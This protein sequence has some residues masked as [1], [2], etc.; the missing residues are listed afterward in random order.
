[1]IIADIVTLT[2]KNESVANSG[3][4]DIDDIGEGSDALL[5]HTD[6]MN[7]CTNTM[8]QTRAGDWYYPDGTRV[9]IMGMTEEEF[10]R[11]R[12]TQVVRLSY[13]N[14]SFTQEGLFKCVVPDAKGIERTVYVNIGM[15]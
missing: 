13:R 2:L 8:G 9:G 3:Y 6:R 5:C 10:Y 14:S 4:V 15:Y 12:S 1:M 11:D 7:C